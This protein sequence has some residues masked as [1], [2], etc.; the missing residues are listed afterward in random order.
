MQTWLVGGKA[1]SR[2]PLYLVMPQPVVAHSKPTGKSSSAS[3]RHTAD[4]VSEKRAGV[5]SFS[6]VMSLRTVSMLNLGFLKTCGVRP[7][8][9]SEALA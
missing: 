3:G 8:L 5:A 9:G 1:A 6:R 2:S 7:E 4:T